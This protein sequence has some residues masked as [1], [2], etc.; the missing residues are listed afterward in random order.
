[1][2]QIDCKNTHLDECEA[3]E[4][5]FRGMIRGDQEF[6][7]MLEDDREFPRKLENSRECSR[8]QVLEV[9]EVHN[10]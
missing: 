1:M 9:D 2:N 3:S 7:R 6:S 8:M 5:L 10:E 4:S